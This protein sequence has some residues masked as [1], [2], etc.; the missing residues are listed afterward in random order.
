MM[1]LLCFV[2]AK[3]LTMSNLTVRIVL[4]IAFCGK[5]YLMT[6]Y[7]VYIYIHKNIHKII[8]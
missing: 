7:T 8:K 1:N 2:M 3:G 5:R 4:A 6:T